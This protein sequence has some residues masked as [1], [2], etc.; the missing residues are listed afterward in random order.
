MSDALIIRDALPG[1]EDVLLAMFRA[2]AEFEKLPHCL[3]RE[4]I[5]REFMG[6]FRRVQCDVA[7]VGGTPAG[8]MTWLRTY[9]TFQAA[10]VIFLEDIFVQPAF[11]RRGIGRALLKHLAQQAVAEGAV[12]V[13][14]IVLDWNSS[15]IEFYESIGAP[16][17]Q[18]WRLCGLTGDALKALANA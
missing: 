11:R 12:R 13:H 16:V 8:V 2:F 18:E 5:G 14:W 6:E 9:A 15:A 10:P 1:D 4:I 3:T 17:A 7:E